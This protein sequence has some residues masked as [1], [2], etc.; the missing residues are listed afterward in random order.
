MPVV[1]V[2]GLHK[3][4][5]PVPA[6]R[7][8]DLTVSD[9]EI[10]ALLGPNG[11]GKTTT[12][13]I[14]EGY[15]PPDAGT[16][17]VLGME[18]AAGGTR[19][20][21]RIGIVLQ[22][23]GIERELT[24]REALARLSSLYTRPAPPEELI[25]LVGLGEKAGARIKTLSGG[26]RRRLDLA[27]ALAGHPEL[28]FLD[29]PTTGFDPAARREAWDLV[30]RLAA[31]GTS[32]LLTTHYLDEAQRLADRVAVI[33]GGRIVAE[34]DPAS[35]GGRATAEARILF[36]RPD[37]DLPALPGATVVTRGETVEVTAADLVPALHALTAW[38]IDGGREL[39]GL[40]VVRPTLE[41]VYLALVGETG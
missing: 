41:D 22:Q 35:L 12:V 28:V 38:A 5:G 39:T 14:L 32:V 30:T 37:G 1:E 33:A 7:G 27:A 4:Y 29:E 21:D 34:G 16:V 10:V 40:E 23:S 36:R 11:A 31:E 18:P 2:S 24:V 3:S 19:L 15:R 17:R 20:R 6:V 9:G 8:I 25:A 26:Q 13:E